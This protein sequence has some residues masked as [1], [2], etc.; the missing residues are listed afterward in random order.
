MGKELTFLIQRTAAQI[1]NYSHLIHSKNKQDNTYCV[2]G[3]ATHTI[4][5]HCRAWGVL[6]DLQL[7][8]LRFFFVT[9]VFHAKHI[10]LQQAW[11]ALHNT[12]R[13]YAKRIKS[14]REISYTININWKNK[15]YCDHIKPQE[16]RAMNNHKGERILHSTWSFYMVLGK[17]AKQQKC[18][19]TYE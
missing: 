17:A 3:P 15:I 19:H 9:W 8:F 10:K 11:K 18:Q 14:L 1:Q 12:K 5:I 13:R 6:M 4:G 16:N 7:C 2:Q